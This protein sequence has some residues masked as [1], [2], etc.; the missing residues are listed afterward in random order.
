MVTAKPG[1]AG[2]SNAEQE[3]CDGIRNGEQRH[4]GA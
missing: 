3:G 1:T 2:L 4:G